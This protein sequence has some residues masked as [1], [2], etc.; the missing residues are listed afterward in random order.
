MPRL[1]QHE[2]CH[3][4]KIATIFTIPN[5]IHNYYPMLNKTNLSLK[6]NRPLLISTNLSFFYGI[7]VH[8]YVIN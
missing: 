8:K 3:N 7:Y 6:Q 4:N 5:E 1:I 2:F